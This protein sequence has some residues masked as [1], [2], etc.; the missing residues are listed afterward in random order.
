M[1]ND[2]SSKQKFMGSWDIEYYSTTTR[3]DLPTST[4]TFQPLKQ[5]IPLDINEANFDY[6]YV[7]SKYKDNKL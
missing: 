3:Q 2:P 1:E 6:P 7:I 4:I 5:I